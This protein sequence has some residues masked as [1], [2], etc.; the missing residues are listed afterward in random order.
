VKTATISFGQAMPELEMLRAHEATVACDL[1]VVLGTSLVVY[2]AAG[3]PVLAKR[4]G[5]KLAILN[6]EPTEQDAI[7]DL[8]IHAEIGPTLSAAVN[9][10]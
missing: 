7:A 10:L 2:P 1:F 5:A 9:A 6:R 8:A 3:F 4:H